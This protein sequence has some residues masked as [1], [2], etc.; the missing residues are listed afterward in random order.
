MLIQ[1][2]LLNYISYLSLLKLIKV[3][4]ENKVKRKKAILFSC[5]FNTFIKSSVAYNLTN[6]S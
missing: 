6:K 4:D 3:G 1:V 2:Y 5:L